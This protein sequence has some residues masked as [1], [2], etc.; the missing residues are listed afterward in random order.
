VNEYILAAT[1]G[2][3]ETEALVVHEPLN[4]A[5]HAC[6]RIVPRDSVKPPTNLQTT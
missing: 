5:C 4:R 3:D 6:H 2:L 1:V